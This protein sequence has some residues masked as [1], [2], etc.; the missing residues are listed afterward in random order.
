VRAAWLGLGLFLLGCDQLQRIGGD[1]GACVPAQV[2]AALDRSCALSGCH[3]ASGGGAGL[4]LTSSGSADVIGRAASQKT[5]PLVVIGDPAGSYLAHKLMDDPPEPIVNARM[6]IAFDPSNEAQSADVATILAWIAGAPFAGCAAGDESGDVA[7]TGTG[8]ESSG[9]A[10]TG[11]ASGLPCEVDAILAQRCR[12][13]HSD[14]PIGAPMSLVTH[15]DLLA[16]S[17]VDASMTNAER[18]LARMTDSML[19]MPPAPGSPV[20]AD[21]IA[22]IEAWI[23]AGAPAKA[24]GGNDTTGGDPMDP[25]DVEPTCSSAS[26]WD[27]SDDDGTP[28]MYPGRD[29]IGCHADER[30]DDPDDEDIPDLVIAGTLYATGHEPND[31]NGATDDALRVVVA[32][33]ASGVEVSLTPN[34]AGNFLLH[35]S[36]APADFDAPFTVKVTDGELERIMPIAAPSGACNSCHTQDGTM[37]APGRVVIPY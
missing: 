37:N 8:E 5:M 17:N 14:P 11:I 31:C 1:D 2:Q 35:R 22:V 4:V 23:G 25:F 21:E 9:G 28:V 34:S 27:P 19:P 16:P 12:S 33:M 20:P 7:D 15:D 3:D 29:C 32:S 6:P 10:D 36:E 13:C 30:A 26:Y 24:C 18:V